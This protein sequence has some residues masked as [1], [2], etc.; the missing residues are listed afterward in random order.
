MGF[1]YYTLL[2]FGHVV[3]KL[4]IWSM[5]YKQSQWSTNYKSDKP[6]DSIHSFGSIDECRDHLES[7]ATPRRVI[8][9]DIPF[10]ATLNTPDE[11]PKDSSER[12]RI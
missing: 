12:H 10:S 3:Y 9:Q 6:E 1:H 11:T 5:S 2:L 8:G 7:S 4:T